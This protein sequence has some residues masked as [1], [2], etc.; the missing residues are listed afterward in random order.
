MKYKAVCNSRLNECEAPLTKLVSASLTL[1][2]SPVKDT[3][4]EGEGGIW[5]FSKL[6]GLNGGEKESR[7]GEEWK[8]EKERGGRVTAED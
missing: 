8:G 4:K 6:G 2:R 5:K 3:V 1:E 7:R